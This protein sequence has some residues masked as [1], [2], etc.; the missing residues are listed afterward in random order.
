MGLA[1]GSSND[2]KGV[3]PTIA[4]SFFPQTKESMA[5]KK[6]EKKAKKQAKRDKKRGSANGEAKTAA[7]AGAETNTSTAEAVTA[8]GRDNSE[9]RVDKRNLRARVEEVDDE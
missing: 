7:S 5:A 8:T 9:G 4:D 1:R 3:Q 6:I 2:C